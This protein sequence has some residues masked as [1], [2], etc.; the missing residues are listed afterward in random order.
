[1]AGPGARH[2]MIST[3]QG[4]ISASINHPRLQAETKE[5][6]CQASVHSSVDEVVGFDVGDGGVIG[7]PHRLQ[8]V[9]AEYCCGSAAGASVASVGVVP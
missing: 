1:M 9:P 6:P 7:L 2:G 4:H 3:K 5:T 8:H